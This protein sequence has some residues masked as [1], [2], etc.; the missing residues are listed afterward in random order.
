MRKP[1]GTAVLSTIVGA[2]LCF[3]VFDRLVLKKDQAP[4]PKVAGQRIALD[5]AKFLHTGLRDPSTNLEYHNLVCD[6]E[7]CAF[8]SPASVSTWAWNLMGASALAAALPSDEKNQAALDRNYEA[9]KSRIAN[10]KG[11]ES[12]FYGL[13]Y[14]MHE[15]YRAFEVTKDLKYLALFFH[16]ADYIGLSLRNPN[17]GKNIVPMLMATYAIQFSM[18]SS[19]LGDPEKVKLLRGQEITVSGMQVPLLTGTEAELKAKR[20]EYQ[21]SARMSRDFLV[22]EIER[23]KKEI[24]DY[25]P[26]S[27]H[28][29]IVDDSCWLQLVNLY[30]YRDTG[31]KT[32]LNE[33]NRFFEAAQFEKIPEESVHWKNLQSVL[34]CADVAKQLRRGSD[35]YSKAFHAIVQTSIVK[36]WDSSIRPICSGDGGVLA[37]LILDGAR[38][39]LCSLNAKFSVDNSWVVFLL[40]DII[41]QFEV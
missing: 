38:P 34:P 4:R 10:V 16:K 29:E 41:E 37:K 1:S 17:T 18:A 12:E 6:Q 9:L 5:A 31:D 24:A 21:E 3:F 8:D 33:V 13:A 26:V 14:H 2:V 40:A 25:F 35:L 28:S 15:L 22:A 20:D 7:R 39:N 19:V 11:N 23:R 27:G 30:A 36:S 32:Y